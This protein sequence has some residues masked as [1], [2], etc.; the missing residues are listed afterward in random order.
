MK[1]LLLV[2]A[3]LSSVVSLSGCLIRDH[4]DGGPGRYNNNGP[5]RHCDD[6]DRHDNNCN[7]HD[8]HN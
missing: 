8:H 3:L 5:D 2:A 4:R 6:R 7:D 1:R